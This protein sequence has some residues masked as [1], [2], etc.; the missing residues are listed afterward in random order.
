MRKY[1]A[2]FKVTWQYNFE[3]RFEVLSHLILGLMSF[4]VLLFVWTA[5]FKQKPNFNGYTLSKM[6]TYLV[7]VKVLHFLTRGNTS[8]VIATEIKEGK[9]SIYLLKPISY[10]KFWFSSFLADRSFEI[11]VRSLLMIVFLLVLP[12]YFKFPS[13][14]HLF[15]FLLFLPISLFI[16]FLINLLIA[17]TAFYVTDI[18]VL[19]TSVGLLTGFLAGQLI[20]IDLFPGF[21]KNIS[22]FLPF[23]YNIYFLIKIYQGG[24]NNSQIINGF[25]GAFLWVIFL[26]AI[27]LIGWKR[28]LK[29]YEAIGQ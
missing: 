27:L 29:K 28:G 22:L 23:Q 26:T 18:R 8:R 12:A 19:N 21:L 4:F 2:V 11:L 20:P 13:L 17:V 5:I 7:M 9:L 10:L 24:L 3:Y 15:Q 16:N 1:W 6:I 14:I 25:L